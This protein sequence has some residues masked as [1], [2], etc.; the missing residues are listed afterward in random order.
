MNILLIGAQGTLGRAV[1]EELGPRHTLITA[2]RNSG[3]LRID[4][5]D[6]DSIAAALA[7]AGQLDAVISAAGNVA[8]G[9]LLELT[10]EQWE[11]GLRDKL[12]GQVNLALLA[13]PL[14]ADGGSITLTTGVLAEDPIR[15]GASATLVNAG[16]E[17]FVRA[18]A[19]ELPRGVRIN[20]VS[21]GV[22]QESMPG[23]APYFRGFEA[24]PAARA[25]LGFSRS[26]E[27][28]QTG[29]VYRIA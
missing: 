22:L 13:A 26:V 5:T 9:G 23:Y 2:G 10:P 25:A 27:G 16:I 14:L 4:L 29:Q 8:F 15:Y 11:I 3:D 12:M 28:A 21:P 19:L 6:R 20:A 18:A 17:G 24:V 1:A 7:R